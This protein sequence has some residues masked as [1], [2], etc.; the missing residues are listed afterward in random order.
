MWYRGLLSNTQR[1][2]TWQAGRITSR[3]GNGGT[4]RQEAQPRWKKRQQDWLGLPAPNL[5]F[6]P[7]MAL[8]VRKAAF[9]ANTVGLRL[10]SQQTGCAGG[11][12]RMMQ[13]VPRN[14]TVS[15]VGG[16]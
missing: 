5:G 8:R 10:S 16:C 11:E 13:G 12:A 4:G 1:V 14:Q 6:L 15:A 7:E 3:K 9:E 2:L